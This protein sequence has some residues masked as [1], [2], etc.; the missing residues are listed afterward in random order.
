[1][2][3]KMQAEAAELEKASSSHSQSQRPK[4][5]KEVPTILHPSLLLL[6]LCKMII[7]DIV[8]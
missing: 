1:M 6:I 8:L 4:L 3:Y 7:I 5:T 2:I